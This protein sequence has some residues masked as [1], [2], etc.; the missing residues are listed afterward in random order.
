MPCQFFKSYRNLKNILSDLAFL[1][2]VICIQETHLSPKYNPIFPGYTVI[3]K[4][5][6]PHR[7]KG[8]GLAICVRQSV[9]H[10]DIDISPRDSHLEISGI[11][12]SAVSIFTIYNPPSNNFTIETFDFL[13]GL[14]NVV[15]CGDFNSHHGKWG[16]HLSNSNF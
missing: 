8:G 4:D 14:R 10:S 7:S 9:V 1:P 5:R 3:R 2:D 15:L 6:P 13:S 16:S 12:I 11:K